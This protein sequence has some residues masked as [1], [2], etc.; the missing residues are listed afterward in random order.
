M[1]PLFLISNSKGREFLGSD[2]LLLLLLLHIWTQ[3]TI[4][5]ENV[6][7]LDVWP[8]VPLAKGLN[9]HT[10][11]FLSWKGLSG[12][13]IRI[14]G[15]KFLPLRLLPLSYKQGEQGP[16]PQQERG[17]GNYERNGHPTKKYSSR[18][19][20][21]KRGALGL[22]ATGPTEVM[23]SNITIQHLTCW[24]EEES[25]GF[26]SH[27]KHTFLNIYRA[28]FCWWWCLLIL[29]S[30]QG[31]AVEPR[32]TLTFHSSPLSPKHAG[33]RKST[34]TKG[35]LRTFLDLKQPIYG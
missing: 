23:L 9:C 28:V 34:L 31:L 7:G 3:D 15:S 5:G 6:G 8:G 35:Y 13:L 32:L 16:P 17:N 21:R 12:W 4:W 24:V 27:P 11:E 18:N 19:S 20:L 26:Y 14:P 25:L 29:F 33:P 22:W 1:S 2:L 30:K 10:V